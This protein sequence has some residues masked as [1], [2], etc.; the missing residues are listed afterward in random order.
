M[1]PLVSHRIRLLGRKA[2]RLEQFEAGDAG[3]A[4]AVAHQLGV[5]DVAPG[6]IERVDQAGGRDDRGAVLVVMEDRD[7]HQ[8]AQ[9]LLDDE[10][11][12]RL[13]VFQID[14]APAG[15]EQLDAIDELVRVLGGD[16]QIDGVDVGEALEQH[17]LAFHHGLGR[18]RAEIAQP[19]NRG[20]VGDDGDEIALDRVVVGAARIL[21]DGEHR[22]RDARRIGERQVAL[23][24]H[25]LGGDDFQLAG[26]PDAMKLQGFL[27]GEGR[28]IAAA[29]GFC[30]HCYSM[31]QPVMPGE[32]TLAEPTEP[33]QGNPGAA[34]APVEPARAQGVI[35]TVTQGKDRPIMI[36]F[37]FRFLGL[38]CLAAAF[39]LVIY[40]G[41]KS[42]AGN[43]LFL[44]S[45]RTLWEL[46]NAGSLARLKPLIEPYAGGLLWDPVMVSH[47]GGADLEPARPVRHP[48]AYARP[49]EEA[50]DRLRALTPDVGVNA[51]CAR[52]AES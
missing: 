8:F 37:L 51:A 2:D 9:A 11:L 13:D 3:G 48:A 45:V 27:V 4:G 43:S 22:H 1:T 26:P 50:A 19:Q 21:G 30:G 49:Q 10:A 36:R 17:R 7:V 18:Q 33:T 15:A 25:R 46:F 34:E 44:T 20:A 29:G 47:P 28:P 16:F 24:R 40:D 52:L 12:G 32:G 35:G 14:A 41:T 42:I 23:G 31:T 5:L 39:I 38:I 6:Q